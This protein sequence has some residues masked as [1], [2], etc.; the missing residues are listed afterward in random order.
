[1]PG[2]IFAFCAVV[3]YLALQLDRAPPIVIGEAMQPRSFPIFLIGLIAVLNADPD[4]AAGERQRDAAKCAAAADLAQ[5]GLMAVFYVLATYVDLFV[6]LAVVIFVMCIVWGERRC[7]W[8]GWWRSS[9]RH[10]SSFCSTSFSGSAS[11]A[12]S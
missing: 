12:A 10:R 11:R 1:M 8:P 9:R 6:G 2:L 7:G 5:H 3:A 4:L